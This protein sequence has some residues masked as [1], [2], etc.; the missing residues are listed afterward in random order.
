MA[1]QKNEPPNADERKGSVGSYVAEVGNAQPRALISEVVIG[2][3]LRD[4]RCK[5]DSG[6]DENGKAAKQNNAGLAGN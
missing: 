5:N 3:G 4:T 2:E 6:N 1:E